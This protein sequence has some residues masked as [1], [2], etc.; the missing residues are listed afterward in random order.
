MRYVLVGVGSAVVI[1]GALL[2]ADRRRVAGGGKSPWLSWAAFVGGVL[3][4]VLLGTSIAA[5][6]LSPDG[7]VDRIGPWLLSASMTLGAVGLVSALVC[8]SRRDRSWRT[9]VGLIGSGLVSAFW[10]V[11]LVG[12]VVYPH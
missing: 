7:G 3:G 10:L 6:W 11:F 4:V 9:W 2:V 5:T 12:E 1:A 8:A